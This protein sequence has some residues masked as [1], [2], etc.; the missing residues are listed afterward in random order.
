MRII[1]DTSALNAP[2]IDV[3]ARIGWI[4]RM[5]RVT[6]TTTDDTRLAALARRTGV[7]TA[8]L[9]RIETGKRRDGAVA[10]AYEREFGLVESSLRSPIDIVCRTFPQHSPRDSAPGE[11]SSDVETFSRLTEE[12][13]EGAP[14]TGGTWVRWARILARPHNVSLPVSLFLPLCRRLVDE[15]ARSVSHAYAPRRD[16]LALLRTSAYADVVLQAAREAVE[17]PCTPGMTSLLGVIGK[18]ADP[19]AAGWAFEL[20]ES[21]RPAL[22][23]AGAHALEHMGQ[24]HGIRHWRSSAE[25]LVKAYDTSDPGSAR[26]QWT[27]HLIR[28]APRAVWQDLAVTPT[29]RLPPAP[30]I[31]DW[32]RDTDLWE[33]C[34]RT[35]HSVTEPL[36]LPAQPMLTRM[37]FDATFTPWESRAVTSYILIGAVP[38]LAHTLTNRLAVHVEEVEDSPMRDRA[39]RR[40]MGIRHS[41]PI[42]TTERWFDSDSEMLRRAAYKAAGSSG[43]VVP[44]E[45]LLRGLLDPGT[46]DQAVYAAGMSE[47]PD[48]ERLS[49][50]STL[51]PSTRAALAW[52]VGRGG[53][54]TL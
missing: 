10:T 49:G 52:W 8:Q 12:L 21:D 42:P 11:A 7:S 35:A 20:V 14:V 23:E 27:A 47:H 3:G 26:E 15:L 33:L 51:G 48:L 28:V 24:V 9:S 6:S 29:R 50:D 2:A 4:T 54:I 44:L 41:S 37:L 1:D 43:T 39:A 22:T 5:A 34:T 30:E 25:R 40:L 31:N 19:A 53:R 36:G 13:L 38:A 18:A 45:R 46:R 17:A 32:S 16:A